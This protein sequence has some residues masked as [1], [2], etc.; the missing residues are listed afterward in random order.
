MPIMTTKRVYWKTALREL[1][2]FLSGETN[3]R[4][5]LQQNVRIWSDWPLKKY[6]EATGHQISQED[7]EA[8]IIESEDFAASWGDLGPVYGSQWRN[9]QKDGRS[10][11]QIGDLVHTLKTN[12][13]SR[14]MLFH[15]WNVGELENMALPP[16]HMVYQYHVTSDGRLNSM[17]L[18]RSVDCVL[19]LPF[20]LFAQAAL[21]A[22]LAQQ[23][24]LKL[25]EMVWTGGD[26]HVY[27]NHLEAVTQLTAR[28][29]RAFPTLK[30]RKAA[31]IDDYCFEDFE[32][33]G[34]DPHPPISAPVA[35]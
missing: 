30:L 25:G 23:A 34:Y 22:M 35:V 6:R 26:T 28:A 24:G 3:I 15:A 14:R 21:Q 5:L 2:W 17:M 1:L 13:A 11:D 31:S 19:G 7:F 33:H 27:L 32:I 10:Y 9:W 16:C 18:Q 20:N 4:P 8:G 29:P 12:P